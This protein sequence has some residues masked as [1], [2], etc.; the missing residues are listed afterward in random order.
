MKPIPLSFAD[1]WTEVALDS[2]KSLRER[3]GALRGIAAL[4][5]ASQKA[6]IAIHTLLADSEPEIRKQIN[7]TLTAVRDP[8]VVEKLAKACQPYASQFD[9]LA[10][11]SSLCLRE[12]ASFGPAGRAAGDSLMPF[13]ASANGAERSYGILTLGYIDYSQAMAKMEE[14]LDSTDWRTVYAAIWG[15]GWLGDQNAIAK[16]DKLAFT[17]WL[18]EVK[19]DAAH[20]AE[21]LRSPKGRV[22]RRPWNI[23][24][25]GIESDPTDV[26]TEGFRGSQ[27][28]CSGERWKWQGE[29]VKLARS[30]DA[31]AHALNFGNANMWGDL[32][33][34][35]HG[36]WSGELIWVPKQGTPAVL[37]RDNVHGMDYD[38]GGAIVLFGIA[39]LGFNYGYVLRVSRDADGTWTQR[40]IARLPGEPD[41][42][43]RLEDDR[44]AVL[45]AGRVVVLS[46]K[47]GILG[48]A[49]CANN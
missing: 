39:H 33:G 15:V 32:V 49:S 21:E 29:T 31:E 38:N 25:R 47:E 36:E 34:T 46:S 8:I 30:R 2:R 3:L 13:L 24:D 41:R 16:L 6:C 17:F 12:I 10:L 7:M 37:A 35:D 26:I 45:T 1:T 42:W 14:F 43:T 23:N 28:S 5:P 18:V 11:K 9:F 27:R 19:E 44:I 4:G 22:E 20:V 40:E 48:V